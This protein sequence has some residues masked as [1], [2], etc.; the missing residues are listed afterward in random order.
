MAPFVHGDIIVEHAREG[1]C[2]FTRA[3]NCRTVEQA[4]GSNFKMVC[5]L[6]ETSFVHGGDNCRTCKG[7]YSLPT[8]RQLGAES[9]IQNYARQ[10]KQA[11]VWRHDAHQV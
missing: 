7:R 10:E 1:S 2:L 4:G 5:M 6:R 11:R 8:G 3:N 9:V